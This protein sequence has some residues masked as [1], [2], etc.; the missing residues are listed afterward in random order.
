MDKKLNALLGLVMLAAI[1]LGFNLFTASS[2]RGVR[3]DL[4][5]A[6]LFTLSEGARKIARNVPEKITLTYY[7]SAKLAQG[8]PSIQDYGQRVRDLLTEFARNSG[9]MIDLKIV[10]PEPFSEAEDGAVQ[11]GLVGVPL[12]GR[13]GES[14]YMGVVGTT[15]S[16]L[17]QQTVPL[18]DPSAERLLEYDV[19]KLIYTLSTPKKKIVGVISPLPL[20]GGGV[21][22]RTGRPAQR[23]PWA[24]MSELRSVFE[25]KQLGVQSEAIDSS[26]DVLVLIHPKNLSDKTLYA[27]DQYVLK[28]GKLV[29]FIDPLCESD[30]AGNPMMG[31]LGGE[32]SSNLTKLFDAWG[33]EMVPA[34]VVGDDQFATTVVMGDSTKPDPVSY[35][36]WLTIDQR[37]VNK[38]D[39]I[40]SQMTRLFI[41]TAGYLQTKQNS[42]ASLTPLISSTA[43]ANGVDANQ[44]QFMPDPKKLLT[45]FQRGK[46]PLVIA[47]RVTGKVPSAFPGGAPD[48]PDAD[49]EKK[50]EK[51]EDKKSDGFIAQAVQPINA[52]V[53]A[54]VDMLADRFWARVEQF[55]GVSLGIRKTADNGDFLMSCVDNLMGSTDLIAIRARGKFTRPFD[56]VDALQREA[57]RKYREKQQLLEASI[58]QTQERIAQ[59]QRARPDSEKSMAGSGILL[60]KEQEAE[61]DK[62]RKTMASSRKELRSVQLNLRQDV[63]EL[64]TRLKIIN[65]TIM[66]ALV[67]L[68][69]VGLGALRSTRRRSTL[70]TMAKAE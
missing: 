2:L 23:P 69:A 33:I 18:F 4:T 46:T 32:R 60:T 67:A 47:A 56:R 28:G 9:G 17:E 52:I 55:G 43:Q 14:I 30:E 5:E 54:D 34:R 11:A 37:G 63:E 38:D 62:L 59:I 35:I 45:E 7:Y 27:I 29:A 49:A 58:N 53:V 6:K 3:L 44:L 51:K 36:C 48:S 61:I 31:G 8:Q 57:E 42:A 16:S 70:A 65:M 24:I 25:V 64:G 66:P 26:I 40:S 19:A 20:E 41:P 22:P 1:F 12:Q 15:A 50:D 68:A 39:P 10:D 13:P 21:D